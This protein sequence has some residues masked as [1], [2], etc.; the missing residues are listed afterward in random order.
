MKTFKVGDWVEITPQSDRNWNYWKSKHEM[1]KGTFAEIERVEHSQDKQHIFYYVRDLDGRA[2]WF[3][4]RHLILTHKQDRRFINNMRESCEKLQEHERVCKKLLNDML[5]DV[6]GEEKEEE[7]FEEFWDDDNAASADELEEDWETVITKPVVPLPG[8]TKSK[9]IKG[10][11][12][13]TKTRIKK[14]PK[15]KAKGKSNSNTKQS[16]TNGGKINTNNM[17]PA[18]WMTDDE[19]EEYLDNV[20][21]IDWL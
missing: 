3:L 16:N 10:K 7:L 19:L 20:Y 6:F 5:N 14:K 11:N 13:K 9:Y 21:G 2:T 17:D 12:K 15:T 18:D 8:K 4:D 1:M